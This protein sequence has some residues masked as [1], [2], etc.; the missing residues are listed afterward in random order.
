MVERIR[1]PADEVVAARFAR[2]GRSGIDL[3]RPPVVERFCRADF[4]RDLDALRQ[5]REIV[6]FAQIVRID[7]RRSPRIAGGEPDGAAAARPQVAGHQD[8]GRRGKRSDGRPHERHRQAHDENLGALAGRRVRYVEQRVAVIVVRGR[9][10]AARLVG[11]AGQQQVILEMAAD[12][13]QVGD[14]GES[15]RAQLVG[16]ADA[17]QHQQARRIDRPGTEQHV[18]LGSH[19]PSGQTHA[20]APAAL[21]LEAEHLGAGEQIDLRLTRSALQT[22]EIGGRCIVAPVALDAELVPADAGRDFPA[23]IGR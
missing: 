16:R 19:D 18:A 22:V 6:G 1:R 12:I 2:P 10:R 9:D 5:H 20:E 13:G 7:D 15:Q 8:I 17:R 4:A 14:A 3:L 23:Q 11:H 21:D